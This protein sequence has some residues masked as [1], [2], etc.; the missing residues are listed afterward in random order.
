MQKAVLAIAALAALAAP[1]LARAGDVSMRVREIPLGR[2]SLRR[3]SPRS[4]STCSRC[5]GS[6]PAPSPTARASCTGRGSPGATRTQT[7]GRVPG[8]TGTSTGPARRAVFS[9]ASKGRCGGSG[10]TRSGRASRVRP[11]RALSQAGMPAIV[12]RAAWGAN[13]EIV[14]AR[15]S[16]APA[17][18]LAVIHHTAGTNSYT[19][20]Q[21]RGD[22]ARY[23]GLPRAGKRLERH[24]LQLSRRSLRHGLRRSRRRRR[25][26]RDRRA[27][28]RVQ[29]RD[30][31][32]C[33]ARQLHQR[34]SATCAAE[35]PREA[36]R[37]ASRRR[38]RRPS[39]DGRLH[40]GRQREVPR[41]QGRDAAGDLRPSRHGA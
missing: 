27:R 24:R 11:A 7:T 10:R 34:R 30:D 14:R 13:E 1:S 40:V 3:C 12:T 15:P 39:L 32:D 2:R 9:S 28:R 33:A 17:V 21:A 26:E 29:H 23:R 20:A 16:V 19:R 25:A 35:R 38:A 36:A 37:V 41:G 22:R 4:T 5:T 6:A 8:T 31:R 18:R